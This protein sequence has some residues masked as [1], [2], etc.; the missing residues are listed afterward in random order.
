MKTMQF[1]LI[2]VLGIFLSLSL[3]GTYI[4]V[5]CLKRQSADGVVIN[6]AGKQRMLTQKMTK[7]S[8]ALS[9]G[10]GSKESLEK[11]VEL[12]D[13]T[14]KGLKS[15][16]NDLGLPL[17]QNIK[18]VNQLNH[19]QKLWKN[20]QI[21][22]DIV[23]ANAVNTH[24]ALLY[25]NEN[26]IKLLKASNKVV[27]MLEGK[28]FDSKTI[29]LAGKQ[30][31]LTQKMVK[32]TLGL[33]Q[34][35]GSV[36]TLK[37]TSIL[38]DETL[39]GLISGDSELG[40]SVMADN[41]ILAQFAD[42]QTL[43]K[44]FYENVGIILNLVPETTNALSYINGHN[45]ELLKEMN[46]AVGMYEKLSK[47]KINTLKMITMIIA[48]VVALTAIMTWFV[49]VRPLVGSLRGLVENLTCGSEQIA[50]ATQEIASASQSLAQGASEQASS[51][52]ET[53]STMEEMSSMTR[54]N[55]DNAQEAANLAKQCSDSAEKGN[56]TVGEMSASIDKMNNSSMEIVNS[57]SM[58]MGEI[59]T[60]S[61]KIAEITKVIDGIAFQTNLLALNAAVEAARA[62]EHGKGFAVVAEEVRNLAQRSAAAAKDTAG[63]I[64]D[65]VEKADKGT[66]LT[67]KCKETL[68]DI[69]DDVKKSTDNTNAALQE[70]VSSVGK[71]TTLTKEI[72][73]ASTEQAEGVNNVNQAIQQMDE[74]TQQIAANAEETASAS[75]ELAAQA[76]TTTDQV[77]M[78]SAQVG[79][80]DNGVSQNAKTTTG[81]KSSTTVKDTGG[82]NKPEALIPMGENRIR[83]C[84]EDYSAF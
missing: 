83:E 53:S 74:V 66:A 28:A 49:I 20:F 54:Q 73:T 27:V 75:E 55:A 79:G 70:I 46:T 64:D 26:N 58:S 81:A 22:L 13:K 35:S 44:S 3:I 18:I 39:K 30:R 57:M 2:L 29:N 1:K 47:G 45:V 56:T 52:E 68:Q 38:F 65:C 40:L 4:T 16:D 82:G 60:S 69:V 24:A 6:L 32:E 48:G 41:A 77:L 21:N 62:G 76:E 84:S 8:L 42:V 50:S 67:S 5:S 14:L 78:L 63:L 72:S 33:V 61:K 43:W 19:V 9:Q 36:D 15:G 37:G 10:T 11:T 17:T 12:F 31:M 71:V 34:G 59:N 23:L 25:I 51:L 80:G 7:E